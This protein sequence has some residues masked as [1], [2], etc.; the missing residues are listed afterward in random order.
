MG[1]DTLRSAARSKSTHSDVRVLAAV[2]LAM[3]NLSAALQAVR[4][5]HGTELAAPASPIKHA[6]TAPQ[7][8]SAQLAIVP[9]ARAEVTRTDAPASRST[10]WLQH[11]KARQ[12]VFAFTAVCAALMLERL[13]TAV[14]ARAIETLVLQTCHA[15]S[16]SADGL[17][18]MA[19]RLAERLTDEVLASPSPAPYPN[20]G[21]ADPTMPKGYP[22][23]G[24]LLVGMLRSQLPP[25]R[26]GTSCA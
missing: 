22:S 26:C 25:M 11:L 13:C 21:T 17:L 9:Y 1:V 8:P 10:G 7:S 23:W 6:E 12:A 4:I 24:T 20:A 2:S 18:S 14:L 16:V 19:S 15:I 3:S 5:V